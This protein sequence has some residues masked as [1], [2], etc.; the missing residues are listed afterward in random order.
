MYEPLKRLA[1][2][3]LKTPHDPPQPP[4]GSHDSVE[5][6]RAS[7]KY[8]SYRMLGF[9]LHL[10]FV[11]LAE[12]VLIGVGV[13]SHEGAFGVVAVIVA[14]YLVVHQFL[15]YFA[16]RLD[17]DLRH[18]IVTDRSLRVREGAWVVREMTITHA[19]VQNLR[20]VQGP[21]QRMFGISALEVDT[22]GGGGGASAKSRHTMGSG[23]TVRLAGI[24]NA[25][26]IRDRILAHLRAR[27]GGTGLGDVDDEAE[28]HPSA[29]APAAGSAAL[30]GALRELRDA[31]RSLRAAAESRG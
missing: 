19:N 13:A 2:S 21:V 16:I 30:V 26:E 15:N 5:I 20:V 31:A 8:L 24:E 1:L 17:F 12:L 4:S 22:A 23:H 14:V 9:W 10:V 27:G 3:V 25:A 6:F 28:R 7:P 11:V 18:Y 29:A